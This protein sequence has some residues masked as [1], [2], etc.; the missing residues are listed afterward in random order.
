MDQ[1]EAGAVGAGHGWQEYWR[2]RLSDKICTAE[3]AAK[4]VGNGHRVFVGTACATPATLTAALEARTAPPDDIELFHF[5]TTDL[6]PVVEGK[7]VSRYQH[8]CFF[9]G[10]EMRDLVS[11]GLA[12]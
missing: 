4:L 12:E 1:A 3:Q 11:R 7:P 5:L 10:T 6:L 2:E 8:R 9:V